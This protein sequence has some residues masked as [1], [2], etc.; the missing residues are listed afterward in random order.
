MKTLKSL[1]FVVV[2]AVGAALLV[3]ATGES[4]ARPSFVSA[5]NWIAVGDKAGF[6]ITSEK[7]DTVGAELYLKTERGWR[8]GRVEN[9]F[10][11]TPIKR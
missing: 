1:L 6:A 2:A 9:P 10:V 11:A 8:R 7:G 4:N 5:E 3:G